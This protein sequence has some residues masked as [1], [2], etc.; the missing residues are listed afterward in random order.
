MRIQQCFLELQLK[1]SGMFFLRHTVHVQTLA[2]II[3][4]QSPETWC[5]RVMPY[6]YAAVCLYDAINCPWGQVVCRCP[7]LIILECVRYEKNIKSPPLM[8]IARSTAGRLTIYTKTQTSGWLSDIRTNSLT[9]QSTVCS[10]FIGGLNWKLW[11]KSQPRRHTL[12]RYVTSSSHAYGPLGL[13][14]AVPACADQQ[15]GT[16]FHRICEAQ[17]LGNSLN[18]GLRAGHL[19]ARTSGGASDRRWLKAR[20]INGLNYLPMPPPDAQRTDCR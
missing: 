3:S 7:W 14:A 4:P 12:D 17:T 2:T 9:I 16:N 13:D 15:F 5:R 8:T 1:M 19:S 11:P 6:Q 20:R 18:T 10:E